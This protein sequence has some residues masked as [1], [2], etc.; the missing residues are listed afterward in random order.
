MTLSTVELS[1]YL[2]ASAS[3]MLSQPPFN[4][5]VFEKSVEDDL[6]EVVIDYMSDD[7]GIDVAADERDLVATIFIFNEKDKKFA[8]GLSDLPFASNRDD[9]IG[10]FGEPSKSGKEIDN[11]IFGVSGAWDRFGKGSYVLHVEYKVGGGGISKVTLMRPDMV[12]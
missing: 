10:A 4:Q 12:P 11:P 3:E 9:V 2:G 1:K 5:F 6:P 8:P 7:G